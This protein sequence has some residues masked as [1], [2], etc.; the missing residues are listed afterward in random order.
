[1]GCPAARDA[2]LK[3][4][5]LHGSGKAGLVGRHLAPVADKLLGR[6]PAVAGERYDK[7]RQMR[8]GFVM[9]DGGR[10][11]FSWP[12]LSASHFRACSKTPVAAAG[13]LF[14]T[15]QDLPS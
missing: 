15:I 7:G 2:A 3:P 10:K 1:M 8:G 11:M 14:S 13:W 12:Y 9:V 6:Q 4:Q 5:A